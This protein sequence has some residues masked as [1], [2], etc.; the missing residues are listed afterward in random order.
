MLPRSHLLAVLVSAAAVLLAWTPPAFAGPRIHVRGTARIDAQ[1]ARDAGDLLVSGALVDDG[2]Q[3]LPNESV[4]FTLAREADPRQIIAFSED[5]LTARSCATGFRDANGPRPANAGGPVLLVT[6]EAGRFCVR[7]TVPRDKYLA[8]IA[9]GGTQLLDGAKL[10]LPVDTG[11]QAITLR[12][13]PE[14]RIVSLDKPQLPVHVVASY[15]EN[16]TTHAGAGLAL[17]LTN[18][19]DEPLGAGATTPAGTFQF[20]VPSER[21][22]P[23]GRG[24]LRIKFKGNADLTKSMHIAPI[25]RHARVVLRVPG[26][27][28]VPQSPD[29]GI[30]LDVT[31]TATAHGSPPGM[32]EAR[33]G[34]VV[35]GAAQLENGKAKLVVTFASPPEETD[36]ELRVRYLP[37]APWYV[38]AEDGIVHVR[39]KGPS[40]WKQAPLFAAGLAVVLWL[41]LGRIKP[42]PRTQ[43]S[44]EQAKPVILGEARVEMV[45]ATKDA[46]AGWSGRVVDAHDAVPIRAARVRIERPGFD[47]AAVVASV[48]ANEAGRFELRAEGDGFDEL[49]VD[50]PLHAELRQPLPPCGELQIALVLRKRR[51]LERLVGWAKRRGRPFDSAME[52]TPGHVK[53]AAGGDF[54]TAKWAD[55]VERAAYGGGDVDARVE[56]EVDRLAPQGAPAASPADPGLTVRDVPPEDEP[57][58]PA[59]PSD[60]P[61][62]GPDKATARGIG[63]PAYDPRS[64]LP[65]AQAGKRPP[66]G[67]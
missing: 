52:P 55:A 19:L 12:F 9:W 1:A 13:D 20:D 41:V 3:T 43:G 62:E 31:A 45:R 23:P 27:L 67:H 58:E 49:V 34:D 2:G 54:A 36:A 40:P 32:L 15:Q 8:T 46:R 60:A 10:D 16:Q 53:R 29:E 21:L 64:T 24:E 39:V 17:F 11:A 25:E 6:D 38:P 28:V 50:G 26:D 7:V 57:T 61:L 18:E 4:A 56:A 35:V 37:S 51:L 63:N 30:S 5:G 33:L 44:H 59:R 42:Q 48:F 14:P 47:R 22:G 65:L 66:G